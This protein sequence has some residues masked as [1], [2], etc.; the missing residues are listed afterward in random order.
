MIMA[1]KDNLSNV[2]ESPWSGEALD[3]KRKGLKELK[4]SKIYDYLQ[5]KKGRLLEIG[6]GHGKMIYSLYLKNP[7]IEY[8]GCDVDEEAIR[9]CREKFLFAKFYRQEAENIQQNNTFDYV[10]VS[11]VLEH[12]RDFKKVIRNAHLA[13]KEGGA[14]IF[15]TVTEN[16]LGIYKLLRFFKPDWSV[17]T[18]G[19][20]N[21][22]TKK[23]IFE[24]IGQYFTIV[25]REYMYHFFGSFFDAVL[26]FATLNRRIR[27]MFEGAEKAK[28]QKTGGV[29]KII[30]FFEW[31][32]CCESQIFKHIA[33]NS[34]CQFI[35]AIKKIGVHE[36]RAA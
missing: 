1:Q 27:K 12:V 15:V 5:G 35:V 4:F 34:S 30:S 33:L 13:L 22:F 8:T 36:D 18:R 24:E 6:C 9:S 20:I 19:H 29:K 11:D 23:Q 2:Q 26:F 32:A 25:K 10:L 17:R 16:D 28:T 31:V 3:D 14:C 7:N 21:Y